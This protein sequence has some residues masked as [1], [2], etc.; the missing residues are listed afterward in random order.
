MKCAHGLTERS[1]K[2]MDPIE[3]L[4][5]KLKP[6][7]NKGLD[8]TRLEY[9][10]IL[11]IAIFDDF[12]TFISILFIEKNTDKVCGSVRIYCNKSDIDNAIIYELHVSPPFRRR[13]YATRL[14]MIAENMASYLRF[15]RIDLEVGSSVWLEDWYKHLGYL[16]DYSQTEGRVKLYKLINDLK[17]E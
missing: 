9:K 5:I 13:H 8:V 2:M 12:C 16:V 3:K 10:P 4:E 15:K 14:M 6:I 11:D 1:I 7:L 17:I